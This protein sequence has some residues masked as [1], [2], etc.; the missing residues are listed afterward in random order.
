MKKNIEI[1]ENFGIHLSKVL[2]SIKHTP[3]SFAKTHSIEIEKILNVINGI[4][5]P[6]Q[7]LLN[8]LEKHRIINFNDF[9]K[10]DESNKFIDKTIEKINLKF[11]SQNSLRTTRTFSRGTSNNKFEY[12]HYSDLAASKFSN[13]LPE[14]IVPIQETESLLNTYGEIPRY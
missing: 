13:I 7:H 14:H 4:D 1:I 6:D 9:L 5:K 2:N 10:T 11:S 8:I 3:Q 12:Y